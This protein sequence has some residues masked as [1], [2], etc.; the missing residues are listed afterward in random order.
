MEPIS[1]ISPT[2][3]EVDCNV[4]IPRD[5]ILDLNEE[6]FKKA[7]DMCGVSIFEGVSTPTAPEV[8]VPDVPSVNPE[9]PFHSVDCNIKIPKDQITSLNKESFKQA[10][11]KC[12]ASF[13]DFDSPSSPT[14]SET[15]SLVDPLNPEQL[16]EPDYIPIDPI[17][18]VDIDNDLI[19]H[20]DINFD[21]DEVDFIGPDPNNFQ[22]IDAPINEDGAVEVSDDL[23]NHM[24]DI[25]FDDD[26]E[27][28]I[29]FEGNVVPEPVYYSAPFEAEPTES[30]V[31]SVGNG[32]FNG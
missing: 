12:G 7:M 18:A 13:I 9:D 20:I 28:F 8:I 25:V 17:D 27:D 5:A 23:V 4:K 19:N 29:D 32:E 1:P 26:D 2:T 14:A 10:M 6:N 22:P 31:E 15:E 11:M 30:Y 16:P 21:D 24:K 3:D